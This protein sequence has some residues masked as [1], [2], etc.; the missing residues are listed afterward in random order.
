MLSRHRGAVKSRADSSIDLDPNAPRVNVPADAGQI[1]AI[2]LLRKKIEGE[3]L[4][5]SAT[6]SRRLNN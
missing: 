2:G 5:V 3:A 1:Q 4:T 6:C